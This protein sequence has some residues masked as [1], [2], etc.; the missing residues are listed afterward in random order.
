LNIID[1][2]AKNALKTVTIVFMNK[3][4]LNVPLD[5]IKLTP[6]S[7]SILITILIINKPLMKSN[8]LFVWKNANLMN[9][10]I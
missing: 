6:L 4:V 3:L 10:G 1:L 9:M 2:N 8:L 5:N 7:H